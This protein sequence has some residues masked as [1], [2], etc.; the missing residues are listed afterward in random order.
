MGCS[1]SHVAESSK[2]TNS[3]T[4]VLVIVG[5]SGVGKGTLINKLKNNFPDK[6]AF[7]ISHTTRGKREGE[8]E[9]KNYYYISKEEFEKVF[10]KIKILLII[11]DR[12]K[13]IHRA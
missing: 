10:F 5:P 7:K 9:G 6:F 2:T 8:E 3:D 4:K 12:R 1:E 11:D 13:T